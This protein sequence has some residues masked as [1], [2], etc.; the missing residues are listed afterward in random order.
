MSL[1]GNARW[2]LL[3]KKENS[4]LKI[5]QSSFIPV[6]AQSLRSKAQ[7]T[8][9]VSL[10]ETIM[11]I[12]CTCSVSSKFWSE[13]EKYIFEKNWIYNCSHSKRFH[14]KVYA[15]GANVCIL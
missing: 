5:L 4:N 14:Y 1:C 13:F 8:D 15:G 6:I 11:H 3:R 10:S 2:S 12:F 9:E 7:M